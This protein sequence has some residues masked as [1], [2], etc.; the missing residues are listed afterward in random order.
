MGP[1]QSRRQDGLH[2]RQS[3]E[4][5]EA[6]PRARKAD[7]EDLGTFQLAQCSESDVD[8]GRTRHRPRLDVG[9]RFGGLDRP[10]YLSMNPNAKIPTIDAHGLIVSDT[11]PVVP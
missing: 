2:Q 4:V 8:R 10:A 11:N 1:C 5:V 3:V 6:P 9:G 7:A